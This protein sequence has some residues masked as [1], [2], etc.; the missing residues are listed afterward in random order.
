M[1][2]VTAGARVELTV[3]IRLADVYGAGWTFEQI[4]KEASTAAIK[5]VREL[6]G[7]N[8]EVIGTPLVTAIWAK[9]KED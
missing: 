1:S 8:A 6:L 7:N 3:E 5:R 2:N 4:Q 9:R